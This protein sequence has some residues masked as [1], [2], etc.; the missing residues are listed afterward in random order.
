MRVSL[1]PL[2]CFFP[3]AA[4]VV[5][6]GAALWDAWISLV[7]ALGLWRVIGRVA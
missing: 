4:L 2:R 7:L 1:L 3:I 6:G 5:I